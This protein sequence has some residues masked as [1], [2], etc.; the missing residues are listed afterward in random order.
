[1]DPSPKNFSL[2]PAGVLGVGAV[3]ALG[4]DVPEIARL[5]GEAPNSARD[6]RRINDTSLAYPAWNSR[7]RRADRFVRMAA[8]AAL[9]AWTS[10][11]RAA[12][13]VPAE[14]VGLIL[15]SGL[16]S[17]GRAFRFIDGMLDFGDAAAL[18][19]DF[20]HSLHGTATAYITELLALR[21]PSLTITDF[22]SGVAQAF[23]L[24]QCWLARGRCQRVLVGA[25]EELG[26]VLLH[27]AAKVL[28]DVPVI[29]GEGAVFFMLG[30]GAAPS[31][32]RLSVVA[33]A[34][35]LDLLLVD[36]PPLRAAA[37]AP[38]ARRT[39]TC[40]PHFGQSASSAAFQLLGGLLALQA[41][42]PPGRVLA[43]A[44]AGAGAIDSAAAFVPS[45]TPDARLVL[46]TRGGM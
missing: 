29:P 22:E 5:L 3:T 44:D 23:L 1:M 41:G 35:H 20:S 37:P 10:A 26:E 12:G 15:T 36:D 45:S 28:G 14:Q 21:G 33:Q 24:A 7:L 38:P 25:V 17:H 13:E 6:P 30:S 4:R 42:R 46:L 19:T 39:A 9:D 34:P 2:P 11:Q 40:S 27:C 32:V 16:G 18:P 43:A 8:L 31:G